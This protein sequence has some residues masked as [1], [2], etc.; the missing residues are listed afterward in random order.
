V[1]VARRPHQRRP[2]AQTL[3]SDGVQ[4]LCLVHGA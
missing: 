4:P 2:P 3:G 1:R